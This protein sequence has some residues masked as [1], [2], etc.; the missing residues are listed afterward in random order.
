[1]WKWT[2]TSHFH[3]YP[4]H[5]KSQAHTDVGSNTRALS[6]TCTLSLTHTQTPAHSP[7][8]RRAPVR[9]PEARRGPQ[10]VAPPPQALWVA[11]A[12]ILECCSHGN[13][14]PDRDHKSDFIFHNVWICAFQVI[15]LTNVTISWTQM[16]FI[17]MTISFITHSFSDVPCSHYIS[18]SPLS[19]SWFLIFF[20]LVTNIG[21]LPVSWVWC[22]SAV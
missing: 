19:R 21:S 3:I 8:L 22:V 5:L 1:M 4:K 12:G 7:V 10:A 9:S 16:S 15:V 20:C 6:H 17:T 14:Y 2:H 13:G 18:H 11:A